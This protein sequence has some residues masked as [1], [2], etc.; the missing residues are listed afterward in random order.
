MLSEDFIQ[1]R[2]GIVWLYILQK[3]QAVVYFGDAH[4]LEQEGQALP[5]V[6]SAVAGIALVS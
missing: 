3:Y 5:K 2:S 6:K 1:L 4:N